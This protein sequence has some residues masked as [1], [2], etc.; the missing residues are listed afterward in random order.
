V[1]RD[2]KEALGCETKVMRAVDADAT[3][4]VH[5]TVTFEMNGKVVGRATVTYDLTEIPNRGMRKAFLEQV[6]H[7]SK[8]FIV[9]PTDDN[10]EVYEQSENGAGIPQPPI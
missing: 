8:T 1:A 2:T 4:V 3:M 9:V 6:R 5:D 10:G 7:G